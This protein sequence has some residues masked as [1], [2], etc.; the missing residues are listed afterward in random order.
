MKQNKL[1]RRK[2][3]KE[4]IGKS[5]AL[6][7]VSSIKPM[8][9]FY[10]SRMSVE[11]KNLEVKE[12]RD[13]GITGFKVSDIGYGAN[14][15]YDPSV[16]AYAIDLGIN[17]IDTGSRYANGNAIKTVGRGIKGRRDKVWISDK[18]IGF[19]KYP[20]LK[21]A[22]FKEWL[23]KGLEDDLKS[24]QTDHIDSILMHNV[25][26]KMYDR[27]DEVYEV[28]EKAK[29]QGKVRFFGMSGHHADFEPIVEKALKT[30]QF[31]FIMPRFNF[32]LD[33]K[34]KEVYKKAYKNGV[35]VIGM[36]TLTGLFELDKKKWEKLNEG[37]KT[38]GRNNEFTVA[39]TQAALKYVLSYPYINIAVLSIKSFDHVKAYL[40]MSGMRMGRNDWKILKEYEKMVYNI[41]CRLD[42]N[43]C[44]SA[45]PYDVPISDILRYRMYFENYHFERLGIEEYARIDPDSRGDKCFRCDAPCMEKCPYG[46]NIKERVSQAH[47]MLSI[48][49]NHC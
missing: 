45:C 2:F 12:Y 22:E 14:A 41:Y 5:L 24:L 40:L 43:C 3:I 4:S 42:C 31:S 7:S 48:Q 39:F 36:K 27:K 25:D 13:L 21:S 46:L 9:N 16:L 28:F 8:K 38:V 26:E 6:G 32:L 35:A 34:K 37:E 33:E 49:T 10:V 29:A 20:D 19:S 44:H 47:E 1:S 11:E 18:F 15:V 17:F 30:K 23:T